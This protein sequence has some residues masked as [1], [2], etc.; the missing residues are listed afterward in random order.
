MDEPDSAALRTFLDG[1]DEHAT[2]RVGI[3]ETYRALRRVK[4]DDLVSDRVLAP[5]GPIELDA[6]IT[7][8]AATLEPAT[9]RTLD[10]IHLAT[11]LALYRLD[12]F[13]TYDRRLAE[14]ARGLGLTVASPT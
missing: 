6:A 8:T 4:V 14:A 7:A 2:S 5:I 11:A 9:L 12:A 13:V 10:A 3:V 1:F